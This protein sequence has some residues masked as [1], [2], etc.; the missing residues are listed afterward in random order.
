MNT[1]QTW[2]ERMS[3]RSETSGD[4]KCF[5]ES[6]KSM[7]RLQRRIEISQAKGG[8]ILTECQK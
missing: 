4:R 7:L 1:R 5:Q 6:R 2:Q 3:W 8:D